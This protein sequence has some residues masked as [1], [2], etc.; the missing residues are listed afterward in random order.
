MSKQLAVAF[1]SLSHMVR[2]GVL[3]LPAEICFLSE[4]K[5]DKL[6]MTA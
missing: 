3:D 6:Q 4:E 1:P 2:N 5:L